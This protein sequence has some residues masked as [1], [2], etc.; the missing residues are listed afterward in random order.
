MEPFCSVIVPTHRRPAQLAEC[1]AALARLD[2]PPDRYEVIVVD[3]GGGMPLDDV[4]E[5]FRDRM[6]VSCL[7][8]RRA[9]PAA[10]RNAGAA[11]AR[12][13]LLAFTDDDCRPR[14]D[15][16]RRLAGRGAPGPATVSA[17]AP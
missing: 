9:G 7:T 2:Y 5:P 12:G 8:G 1:L 3:D 13:D 4:L 17:A 10:A 11:R 16:L 6:A 15:W 14:P